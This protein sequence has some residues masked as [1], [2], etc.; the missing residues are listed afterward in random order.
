MSRDES[1][2]NKVCEICVK[3]KQARS[4]FPTSSNKTTTLFEM[5]HCDLWGLYRTKAHCGASYF[6]TLID[7]FSRSDWLY[8][9]PTKQGVSAPLKDFIS[10]VEKQYSTLLKGIRSVNGTEFMCM[11]SNFRGK[12]IIDETSCVGTPQQNCHV[13]RKHRHILNV[14]RALR[15]EASLPMEFWGERVLTASY[16]INKTLTPILNGKTPFEKLYNRPPLLSQLRGFGCLC[17]SHSQKHTGDKFVSRSVKGVFIGY[18]S[19]K[20]GWCIYNPDTGKIFSSTDVVFAEA[21]FPFAHYI[22][23]YGS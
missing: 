3:S 18:P 5:V 19:G 16:I 17:Y 9:F 6:L 23:W 21:E 8:L 14:A 7:D 11:T 2:Q 10:Y 4:V 22:D 13:E 1:F 15:F 12:G 20:K